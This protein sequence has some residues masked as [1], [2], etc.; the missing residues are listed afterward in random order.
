VESSR[1]I[2]AFNAYITGFEP[3]MPMDGALTASMKL[4]LSGAPTIV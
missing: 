1:S 4:K 2:W 3:D